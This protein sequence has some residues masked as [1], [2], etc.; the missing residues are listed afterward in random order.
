MAKG[1]KG[2]STASDKT[3]T[4]YILHNEIVKKVRYIALMD[5]REIT[6]VVDKALREYIDKWEKKNGAIPKK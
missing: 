6:D 2:S 4:S 5:E 1:V 3:R